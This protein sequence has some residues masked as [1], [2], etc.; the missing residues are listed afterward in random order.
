MHSHET[1]CG[2]SALRG[3]LAK[4]IP[5]ALLTFGLSI[6]SPPLMAGVSSRVICWGH[7]GWGQTNVPVDLTT[8]VSIVGGYGHSLALRANGSM[9]NWGT[10]LSG[11]NHRFSIF[12][13]NGISNI[14]SIAASYGHDLA[15]AS[16]GSVYGW[17]VFFTMPTNL[18][19][20]SAIAT[21]FSGI[22][23]GLMPDGTVTNFGS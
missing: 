11:D 12:T 9:I 19:K 21:D 7:N 14:V 23:W 18:P 10:F 16:N 15:L 4:G 17:G 3:V 5:F 6:F 22:S 20:L 13:T 2:Q 1:R 8:A